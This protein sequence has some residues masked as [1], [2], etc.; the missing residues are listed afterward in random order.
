MRIKEG[1]QHTWSL[2]C[3]SYLTVRESS[4]EKVLSNLTPERAAVWNEG[5]R[6]GKENS[7][8]GRWCAG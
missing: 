2:Q 6:Q 5:Q 7:G 4:E 8:G 1:D 3:D